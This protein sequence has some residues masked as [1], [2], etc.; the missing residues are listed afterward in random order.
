MA[1][2]QVDVGGNETAVLRIRIP[3]VFDASE[4][5]I[6]LPVFS[7]AAHIVVEDAPAIAGF[8][9]IVESLSE[10]RCKGIAWTPFFGDAHV[11]YK[12]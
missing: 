4:G 7:I 10:G 5:F 2:N 11:V 12:P 3:I 8:V 9:A 1:S 6:I